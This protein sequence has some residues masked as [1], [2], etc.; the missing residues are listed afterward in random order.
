MLYKVHSCASDS[1]HFASVD[2]KN[3]NQILYFAVPGKFWKPSICNCFSPRCKKTFEGYCQPIGGKNE[4]PLGKAM[5]SVCIAVG[6]QL[7]ATEKILFLLLEIHNTPRG[8]EA[9]ILK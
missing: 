9:R 8:R 6:R 2:I 5:L 7:M 3:R 1:K 4:K